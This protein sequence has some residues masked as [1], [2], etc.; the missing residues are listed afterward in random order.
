MLRLKHSMRLGRDLVG[1]ARASRA[2]W[3][4][5][6]VGVLLIV[7]IAAVVTQAAA[8]YTIYTLF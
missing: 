8:P 4:L 6:L 2:W 5:P 1:Y 7:T 3:M